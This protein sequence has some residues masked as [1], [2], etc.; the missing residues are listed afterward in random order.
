MEEELVSYW[1]GIYQKERN[2][3][4]NVWNEDKRREYERKMND[5]SN[6]VIKGEEIF[7]VP[8]ILR[9]HMDAVGE[10]EA[11]CKKMP[12]KEISTTET[13]AILK[14]LK[15]GKAAGPDQLKPEFFKI[16]A[17]S[18]KCLEAL[19]ESLNKILESGKT[20][21][22][23]A[24]SSTRMIPKVSKPEAKNLRPIS[25]INQLII[26]NIYENNERENRHTPQGKWRRKG[27]TS[28]IHQWEANRGQFI[29]APVLHKAN[30]RKEETALCSSP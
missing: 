16:L 27:G 19:K 22:N 26:Q 5:E 18:K 29:L 28:G 30:I 9:E 11:S 8:A 14:S 24:E 2:N 4:P 20:P 1:K 7:E 15:G 23:W 17:R 12:H 13:E 6:I 3:I 10:V 21:S 25:L